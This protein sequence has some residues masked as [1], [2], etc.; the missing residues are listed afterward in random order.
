MK[1]LFLGAGAIGGYFGARLIQN[2]QDVSFLLR[3]A[4]KALLDAQGLTVTSP[5]GNWQGP[6]RSFTEVPA[7]ETF[8]VVVLTCKAYD[9]DAAMQAVAPAIG[10]DTVALP[11]LNGLS[12]LP[13]LNQA[14][15]KDK[16]LG[17]LA[18]IVVT[19]TAD[20]RILHSNDWC[21]ITFGEQDGGLSPRVQAI[22][23]AFPAAGVKVNAVPDIGQQMWEKL[24]HLSTV[25]TVTCLMRACVGDVASVPGGTDTFLRVLHTAADIAAAEGHRP[26]EA[27]MAEY[28]KLFADTGVPYMPSILRDIERGN[29]IEGDHIVGFMVRKARE[30][31]IAAPIH[32]ISWLHL[33][34]YEQRRASGRS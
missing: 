18:K 24:V 15:G 28:R 5:M 30:H 31:G 12:H 33:Q 6:V 14:F 10:P 22:Q 21:I 11:L 19:M 2:G 8:D 34:A 16:V 1:F 23:A 4:R 32:E 26:S 25:A 17:G 7:G 3:P 29:R 9:L 13:R 27:F 20:G